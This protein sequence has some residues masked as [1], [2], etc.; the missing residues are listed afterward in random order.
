MNITSVIK[1]YNSRYFPLLVNI[2]SAAREYISYIILPLRVNITSVVKFKFLTDYFT[3]F[4]YFDLDILRVSI[5][6]VVK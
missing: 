4:G 6:S 5:V 2:T 3:L 1:R